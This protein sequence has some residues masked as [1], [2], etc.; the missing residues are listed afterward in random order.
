MFQ[1]QIAAWNPIYRDAVQSILQ[2]NNST[3]YVAQEALDLERSADTELWIPSETIQDY[4]KNFNN[5]E[6]ELITEKTDLSEVKRR[7]ARDKDIG[8]VLLGHH[9]DRQHKPLLIVFTTDDKFYV[10]DPN[11]V[12]RGIQFLKVQIERNDS[13]ITFWTTN[14]LREAECLYY[15]YSITLHGS[16]AKCCTGLHIHLMKVLSHIPLRA[17]PSIEFYPPKALRQAKKPPQLE[18]FERLVDIWLDVDKQDIYYDMSQLVHLR[19]RPLNVTAINLIKKRC[20]L[21]RKLAECLKY[22]ALVELRLMNSNIFDTL[23][24]INKGAQKT[25]CRELKKSDDDQV[26]HIQYFAH[27]DGSSRGFV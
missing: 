11:D 12:N 5:I 17:T 4:I 21:V 27:L 19:I 15:N 6:I 16:R 13:D 9:I 14:G 2:Q 24:Y 23:T 25:I 10:I 20:I 22:F 7:M 18:R 1:D 26:P 8:L 3:T